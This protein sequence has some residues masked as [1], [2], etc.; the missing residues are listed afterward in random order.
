MLLDVLSC[1]EII[2]DYEKGN[3]WFFFTFYGF[4]KI[5]IF[6]LIWDLFLIGELGSNLQFFEMVTQLFQHYLLNLLF[7]I[8]LTTLISSSGIPFLCNSVDVTSREFW[9]VFWGQWSS[10][11]FRWIVFFFN[12][13]LLLL[14]LINDW[15]FQWLLL[16]P[17]ILW[18]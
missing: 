12:L 10:R 15:F 16:N 14:R 1:L 6:D 13:P 9:K 2:Q 8:I 5:Q 17:S 11:G 3:G 7:C 4:F 18:T